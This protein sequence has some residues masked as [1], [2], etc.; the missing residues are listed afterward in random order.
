MKLPTRLNIPIIALASMLILNNVACAQNAPA[1]VTSDKPQPCYKWINEGTGESVRTAPVR[2]PAGTYAKGQWTDPHTGDSYIRQS[3]GS[4]INEGT[5]EYAHTAPVGAPAGTYAKGQWTDP[6]TGDSYIRVPCGEVKHP[7]STTDGLKTASATDHFQI[8]AGYSYMNADHEVAR[9]L[10]GFVV[11]GFYNFNSWFA[12]GGEFSGLYG[13]HTEHYSDGNVDTSLDRYLYLFGPQMT[14]Q[15]CEQARV[16][17]HV[18]V[19]GAHDYNEVSYPGGSTH[20]SADAFAMAIGG[21]VDVQVTRNLSIGPS[22][23]YAPT[24]FPSAGGDWQNNWRVN[25]V[26]KLRW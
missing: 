26:V 20:S 11:N 22:I 1:P 17:G 23:D 12:F 19:G 6:H 18:L 10:N 4:W 3:D 9:N 24:A 16:Y 2:A 7:S 8:G 15:P 14:W 13:T 25:V 21:G 5:G